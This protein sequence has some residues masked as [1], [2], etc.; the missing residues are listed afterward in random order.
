MSLQGQ[1]LIEVSPWGGRLS[2][3]YHRAQPVE[4]THCGFESLAALWPQLSYHSLLELLFTVANCSGALL[5]LAFLLCWVDGSLRQ[6]TEALRY[7]ASA[8]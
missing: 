1:R 5:K 3:N 4:G 7:C 6:G 2:L 8:A